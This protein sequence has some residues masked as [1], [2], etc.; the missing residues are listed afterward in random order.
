MYR[1]MTAHE[2]WSIIKSG[3]LMPPDLLRV[4]IQQNI[5]N[6]LFNSYEYDRSFFSNYVFSCSTHMVSN[7]F[8][9]DYQ[10]P[11]CWSSFLCRAYLSLA[12]VEFFDSSLGG[13]DCSSVVIAGCVVDGGTGR[14]AG[15]TSD[16]NSFVCV[17]WLTCLFLAI[18]RLDANISRLVKGVCFFGLGS[19]LGPLW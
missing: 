16:D 12:I 14:W 7:E 17:V 10:R 19:G 9:E 18:I 1:N 11:R 15:A 13:V 4:S 8:S 5:T 3:P 2:R 6:S